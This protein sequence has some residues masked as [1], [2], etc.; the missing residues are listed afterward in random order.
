[1]IEVRIW[2]GPMPEMQMSNLGEDQAVGQIRFLRGMVVGLGGDVS[3]GVVV[4]LHGGVW[5]GLDVGGL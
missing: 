3:M 2:C 4:A 1:M 5:V